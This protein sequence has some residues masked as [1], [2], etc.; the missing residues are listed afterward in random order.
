MEI[1]VVPLGH[2][3]TN[4]YMLKGEKGA[5]LIDPGFKSEI[6]KNFLEENKDK[7]RLILLT[8]AHFDHIGGAP[9]LREDSGVKIAIG[10]DE[11]ENLTNPLVNLSVQFHAKFDT[12]NADIALEDGQELTVGDLSFKVMFTPGHTTGGAVYLFDGILFS[13]DTLFYESVGRTDFPGGD[14]EVLENSIRKL[15]T[16]PDSTPVFP[17]HGPQSTIGHEK[18]FNPYVRSL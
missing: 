16:L 6:T 5:I 13:G 1:K 14:G 4:C 18:K 2:I 3:Q 7:E 12:F 9:F 10:K 8:H 15:Y 11:A 17:G